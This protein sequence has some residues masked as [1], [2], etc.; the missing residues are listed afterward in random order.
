MNPLGARLSSAL[1]HTK[2][3]HVLADVGCDHAY[4]PIEAVTLGYVDRSIASDN[5]QKPFENAKRNIADAL[6][7]SKI[8]VVLSEGLDFIDESVDLVTILGMGGYAITDILETSDLS[9]VKRL[10]LSP[11][12]DQYIVRIFLED[13]HFT[14]V[15]EE[16]V[17]ENG[18]YYQI[19]VSEPGEMVLSNNE[20]KYGPIN[21]MKK[22]TELIEFI[23]K[24]LAQLEE[25]VSRT[26]NEETLRSLENEINELKEVLK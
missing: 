17:E 10:I 16:F 14:I 1:K 8:E 5:K 25:A 9:H 21:I 22:S 12:S 15:D 11:N 19:I 3:F 13:H 6:L 18:K 2:G 4:L 26:R 7:E 20:R 23:Q 24:I